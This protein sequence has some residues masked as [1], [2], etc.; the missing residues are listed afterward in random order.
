[1]SIYFK[2]SVTKG[3][4]ICSSKYR[5]LGLPKKVYLKLTK[6]CGQTEREFKDL[7][8]IAKEV[9]RRSG[10]RIWDE[11]LLEFEVGAS[12]RSGS[13][14]SIKGSNSPSNQGPDLIISNQPGEKGVRTLSWLFNKFFR[15]KVNK[16]INVN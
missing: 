11:S 9:I 10:W 16:K 2:E 8:R 3:E 13:I 7:K 12:P 4:D 6:E 15:L 5:L 14:M 1:M